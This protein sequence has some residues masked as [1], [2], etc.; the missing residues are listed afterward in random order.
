MELLIIISLSLHS[1]FLDRFIL[2]VAIPYMY[3]HFRNE[4]MEKNGKKKCCRILIFGF[5]RTLASSRYKRIRWFCAF[6]F[7][8]V[9]VINK[10]KKKTRENFKSKTE[11]ENGVLCYV[12]MFFFVPFRNVRFVNEKPVFGYKNCSTIVYIL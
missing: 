3:I 8:S 10:K 7:I 1:L 11:M 12:C 9:H 6:F 2:S 5:S 4:K